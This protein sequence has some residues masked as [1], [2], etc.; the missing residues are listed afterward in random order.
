MASRFTSKKG[1]TQRQLRAGEVI[2]HALVDI[3]RR[4]G[5]RDP[6]LEGVS[7]TISEV[8]VSPDL[9]QARVFA[10]PLGGGDEVALIAALN[11]AAAF[12]RGLLGKKI[13]LKFTPALIFVTDETFM[14]AQKIESLLARPDV[15]RDLDGD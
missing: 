11:R 14:E 5:L 3:I 10:Y 4:E 7:V 12:L 13:D 1:P 6:V 15:A 9:K 8:Q 2:R